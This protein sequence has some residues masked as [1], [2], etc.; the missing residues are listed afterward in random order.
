MLLNKEQKGYH[1]FHFVNTL[2]KERGD[3]TKCPDYVCD[4]KFDLR[5]ILNAKNKKIFRIVNISEAASYLKDLL[6]LIKE[7]TA[8]LSKFNIP[9]ESLNWEEQGHSLIIK[10]FQTEVLKNYR[11]LRLY[12]G[13]TLFS[14]GKNQTGQQTIKIYGIDTGKKIIPG[15]QFIVFSYFLKHPEKTIK[16][17]TLYKKIKNS[18]TNGPNYYNTNYP[19]ETDQKNLVVQTVNN[20][21]A[22]LKKISLDHNIDITSVI[23]NE[24]SIGYRYNSQSI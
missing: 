6:G 22:K 11:K 1:L 16:Y 2:I 8:F 4:I 23:S 12:A 24:S 21:T 10:G 14:F 19:E 9:K 17:E 13:K 20:L 18:S 7:D 5:T 15:P 3:I